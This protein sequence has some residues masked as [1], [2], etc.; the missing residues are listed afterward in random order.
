MPG[1]DRRLSKEF[2]KI[3]EIAKKHGNQ[4]KNYIT[5]L[6]FVRADQSSGGNHF[7]VRGS[8][9]N[10]QIE[11][12]FKIHN[13]DRKNAVDLKNGWKGYSTPLDAEAF[14][15]PSVQLYTIGPNNYYS[16]FPT[17]R[18]IKDPNS[19]DRIYLNGK[20]LSGEQDKTKIVRGDVLVT[21]SAGRHAVGS[22]LRFSQ[23]PTLSVYREN[24]GNSFYEHKMNALYPYEIFSDPDFRLKYKIDRKDDVVCSICGDECNDHLVSMSDPVYIRKG[25]NAATL[26]Y[27]IGSHLLIGSD[28]TE[29]LL[30]FAKVVLGHEVRDKNVWP[31]EIAM[32]LINDQDATEGVCGYEIS[33]GDS[34]SVLLKDSRIKSMNR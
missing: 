10:A 22:N 5:V 16:L 13:F 29:K 1:S 34:V 28:A 2:P 15:G 17:L 6:S 18:H 9:S 8:V 12:L 21:L 11:E 19:I 26:L 14:M 25:F 27:E 23:M 32:L 30:P 24:L 31:I 33:A 7:R 3:N 4:N 20:M